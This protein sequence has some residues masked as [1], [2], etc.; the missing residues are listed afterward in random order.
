MDVLGPFAVATG[1]PLAVLEQVPSEPL[2]FTGETEDRT[3]DEIIAY[4][5]RKCIESYNFDPLN[6]D[7]G[8][9]NTDPHHDAH[10]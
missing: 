8:W 7:L 3:E 6:P 1:S 4:S 9:Y 10:Q 5:Y 2:L